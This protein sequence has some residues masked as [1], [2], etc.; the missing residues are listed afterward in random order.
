MCFSP[1]EHSP[2]LSQARIV[3]KI[4]KEPG[5]YLP[6]P[7]P[8]TSLWRCVW[9][10]PGPCLDQEWCFHSLLSQS[11][12]PAITRYHMS[13][14]NKRINFSHFW[15]LE[16]VWS[17]WRPV[18]F[19]VRNLFLVM[20]SYV[21]E[22]GIKCFLS[23]LIRILISTW[24]LHPRDLIT[25]QRPQLQ[26]PLHRGWILRKHIQSIA[27]TSATFSLLFTVWVYQSVNSSTLLPA[28][29]WECG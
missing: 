4:S 24:R 11:V 6:P 13:G 29:S 27:R 9:L 19:L 16:S 25:S 23:L 10:C 1:Q 18:R 5:R 8:H 26:M 14:L 20:S 2:W 7:S 3:Q 17:R 21:G 28:G 12:C 15:R 22:R